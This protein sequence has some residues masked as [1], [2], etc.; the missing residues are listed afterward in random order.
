MK[1]LMICDFFP[2][3]YKPYEGVFFLNHAKVLRKLGKIRVQTLIRVNEFKLSYERWNVDKIE[4]EAITFFYKPNFGFIFLPLALLFQFIL[5]FKNLLF[6]RPNRVILQMSLPQGLAYLPFSIF[7]KYIVLEHSEKVLFGINRFFSKIVYNLSDG[8][9][10]VSTFQKNELEN[11][12][13]I[14]IDNIIPNPI[15][16]FNTVSDNTIKNRVIFVGTITQRKDPILILK[17][18]KLL[19]DI[20]FIFVG[21][22]FNDDYYK[23]FIEI[24]STLNNVKYLGHKSHEE[25]LIEIANSDFLIST[26]IYETFGMAMAEALS[27]GKPVIWTDSGGPRDFLNE[28]NSILVKERNENALK[29]AI[30]QAY[31]KLKSGYF[32]PDEIKKGIFDYCGENEVLEAYKRALKL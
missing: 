11:K 20:E 8:N 23:S 19:K 4:V 27:L 17:T 29:E 13:K 26:S 6:F 22:N 31:E 16:N 18:A 28:K 2:N 30:I 25:T 14:R 15:Y 9:F 32:N 21:R 24:A 5:T 1:I 7:K 3:K 12:L 10:V